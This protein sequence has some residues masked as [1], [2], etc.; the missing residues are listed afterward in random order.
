MSK[1]RIV[2]IVWPLLLLGACTEKPQTISSNSRVDAAA[3]QGTGVAPPFM[4]A[5]W[6]GGDK[7]AWESQ[8]KARTQMGQNDYNKVP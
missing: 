2:Y 3:F 8:M 1:R 6:K 4:A 7:G 5:G